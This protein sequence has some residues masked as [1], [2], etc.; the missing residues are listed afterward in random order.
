MTLTE[1]IAAIESCDDLSP[2]K[3]RGLIK[4]IRNWAYLRAWGDVERAAYA[5]GES[6]TSTGNWEERQS[7]VYAHPLMAAFNA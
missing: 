3:R 7:Q 1:L 4:N 6:Y 2:Q 5:R